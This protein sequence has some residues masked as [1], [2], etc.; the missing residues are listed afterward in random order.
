MANSGVL[1][2]DCIELSIMKCGCCTVHVHQDFDAMMSADEVANVIRQIWLERVVPLQGGVEVV[3]APYRK[4]N[5]EMER[6]CYGLD[7]KLI[8]RG[9]I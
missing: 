6:T 3:S 1:F 4:Q 9:D 7:G 5:E 2:Q 8:T